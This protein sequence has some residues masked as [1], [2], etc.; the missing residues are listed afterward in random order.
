MP[1]NPAELERLRTLLNQRLIAL[2]REVRQMQLEDADTPG[3]VA[4]APVEDLAGRS[5]ERLRSA[6][7]H[8]EQERDIGELRDIDTALE[9][10]DKGIY[11]ECADCGIDIPL[12]RLLARPA[13][14]RCHGCQEVYERSHPAVPG[15]APEL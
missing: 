15:I 6:L 4:P 12:P 10:M 3:A 14:S 1:L 2:G 8:A 5:E 7:R 9:R 11:G 13:A